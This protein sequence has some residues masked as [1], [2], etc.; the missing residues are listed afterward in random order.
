MR[1]SLAPLV[2]LLLA[3]GCGAAPP[4]AIEGSVADRVWLEAESC[5][6]PLRVELS[7]ASPCSV[8][9]PPD[10]RCYGTADVRLIRAREI[11]AR[12]ASLVCACLCPDTPPPDIPEC[13]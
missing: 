2:L 8:G 13:Q 11:E 9:L 6:A 10:T 3:C 12:D 7:C 1:T 5:W 4:P